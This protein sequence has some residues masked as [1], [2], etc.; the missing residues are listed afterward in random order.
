[1]SSS[2]DRRT[3]RVTVSI[4]VEVSGTC[5]TGALFFDRTVTVAISRFGGSVLLPRKL[6]PEQD[7]VL[8][9]LENRRETEVQVVG[10][11][12]RDTQGDVYGLRFLGEAGNFWNIEFPALE[13]AREAAMR[14][15]MECQSCHGR[16]VAYLNELE[17]EVFVFSQGLLRGCKKCRAST[18]W[19]EAAAGAAETA[20]PVMQSAYGGS[21]EALVASYDLESVRP[22]SERTQPAAAPRSANDRKHVRN[23]LRI[24]VCIR[25]SKNDPEQWGMDEEVTYTDD[26][27]RGGFGFTSPSV[28]KVGIEIE[29][30]IPFKEGGSN[31]CVPAYIANARKLEDG[32]RRY[33]VAYIRK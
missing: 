31:I 7:L 8:R 21:Q 33:G 3:D 26:C 11:A 15:V 32:R 24:Q 2:K 4:P 5:P 18:E 27:S 28:F 9:N 10:L 6:M 20:Q 30:A 16:Q 23:K 17:A 25:R 13:D 29:A 19:K 12:G 22:P 1:V 14:M